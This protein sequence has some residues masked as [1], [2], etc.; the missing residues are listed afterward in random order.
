MAELYISAK[1][2]KPLFKK[3]VQ[4]RSKRNDE[5]QLI[6]DTFGN[7]KTLA[8][9]YIEPYCTHHNPADYHEHEAISFV[10][11][12][13]F[14]TIN[15]FLSK[16]FFQRDGR[17]QMFILSD[18]GMGKTSVLMMLKL[19]H[20][21][22]FWP[23]S[24]DCVLLKLGTDT[25][26]IINGIK[27]KS[28]TVLLLD[29]LD[30]EPESNEN[31]QIRLNKILE[32][33]SV[34]RRT[35]ITC[36]TQFFP[37]R[38]IDPF[39]RPGRIQV[40]GFVCPQIFLSYFDDDQVDAYLKK[41]FPS[42][43]KGKIKL[44]KEI[45]DKMDSLRL[46]PFLLAHI[47]DIL[48]SERSSWGEYDVFDALVSAWLLREIKKIRAISPSKNID[49]Q[50]L[51]SACIVIAG[52]FNK[53]QRNCISQIE[54]KS[55]IRS[56]PALLHIETIEVCGRSLLNRRSDGLFRFSH[57]SVQEFLIA[58]GIVE[59]K[60]AHINGELYCSDQ[61]LNFLKSKLPAHFNLS[62]MN[63]DFANFARFELKPENLKNCKRLR[64]VNFSGLNLDYFDLQHTDFEGAKFIDCSLIGTDFSH[65]KL[66]NADF[67]GANISGTS[68]SGADPSGANFSG[69]IGLTKHKAHEANIEKE[70]MKIDNRS[71][72][73]TNS[74]NKFNDYII[75]THQKKPSDTEQ[76]N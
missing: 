8:K 44:A 36:R 2:I 51:Y 70:M 29:A 16:E 31:L 19:S 75:K 27:N 42:D 10:R 11:S 12:P 3:L 23:T 18:S 6:A 68:F 17:N 64:F 38:G 72:T 60:F 32:A 7:P 28:C 55:L 14:F 40:G 67:T 73:E 15:D 65:C 35:I 76:K 24:Y 50:E 46:R 61:I 37:T 62:C 20:L 43:N 30:E 47:E 56:Y 71:E 74:E 49:M 39:D 66:K 26:E 13:V 54:L 52:F 45:M 1:W 48:Q 33:T 5:L 41:C 22:S 69:T 4:I 53:N 59:G 63:L 21:L 58:K 9:Y 57:Y 25:L 34:F